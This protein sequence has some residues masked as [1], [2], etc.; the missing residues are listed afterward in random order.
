ME[1][2][3]LRALK[4]AYYSPRNLGHAGLRSPCYCHF[5]SP[6]RR[7]PDLVCHRALLFAVGAGEIAPAA[8]ALAE[9]GAWTSERE[10]DAMTIEREGDD[11]ARCFA[12]ES[13][14]FER[15][16]EESFG[17]EVVGLISAGAFVAFGVS[18]DEQALGPAAAA[19]A[20]AQAREDVRVYEGLLPVRRLAARREPGADAGRDRASV[21]REP[22]AAEWWELN[23]L[24]TMLH[25]RHSGATLRLGQPLEVRVGRVDAQRGRVDLLPVGALAAEG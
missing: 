20:S 17:G 4:Q 11:I 24:G 22:T 14:L 1:T 21:P 13:V 8:G 9:L 16:W 5:T 3:V 12:L 18:S 25:G 19:T 15:G 7:Y 2:L 6:I 23:E 10:R